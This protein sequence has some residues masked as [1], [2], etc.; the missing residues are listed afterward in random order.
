MDFIKYPKTYAIDRELSSTDSLRQILDDNQHLVIE[1]K[2]DGTQLGLQFNA[3]GQPVLQSRG[4]IISNE[5]EFAL[6]KSWAWEHQA[7]LFDAMKTRYI[8]FGEWL[9]EK[10]TIFYDELPSYFLEFDIY[11]RRERI[12]LSTASRQKYI[13]EHGLDFISS[14]RVIKAQPKSLSDLWVLIQS[15]A[16]ISNL[17]YENLS[18]KERSHTDITRKMEGLYLKVENDEKVVRRYKL[19]R[20][21][22][23]AKIIATGEHWKKR[24]TVCNQVADLNSS[25]SA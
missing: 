7:A 6:M 13:Q 25:G 24:E 1:E 21:E 15:S 23:L 2:M 5:K 16:F 3:T 9:R 18:Q 10:H 20:P 11:D 14:V 22:F 8:M 19:I 4:T 12:F 17:A